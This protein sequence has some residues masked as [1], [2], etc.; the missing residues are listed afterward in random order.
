[1]GN[2][3]MKSTLKKTL[4]I[5]TAIA[6]AAAFFSGLILF[7]FFEKWKVIIAHT[8]G[9]DARMAGINIMVKTDQMDIL[10][11][12]KQIRI[13][14][15]CQIL[16]IV[17]CSVISIIMLSR[18]YYIRILQ[19]PIAILKKEAEYIG[20]N[21]L[22]FECKY[23]STDEMGEICRAFNDMRLRLIDNQKS[24][25]EQMEAQRQLN[26]AF[27]HDIRT[28]V[29]VIKGYAQM[30]LEFKASGMLSDEKLE[31]ILNTFLIQA[32][33]VE[34]F[35]STMKELH[36]IDERTVDKKKMTFNSIAAQLKSG[37]EGMSN[38]NISINVLFK[39]DERELFCDINFIHEV[40]DNLVSNAL[41]YAKKNIDISI[42]AEGSTLYVYVRDDGTGFMKDALY[43]AQRPYFT[44][45]KDHFGL[46]LA[47]CRTLCKKHGGD[48]QL[49]NSI[50]GGAIATA[51]FKCNVVK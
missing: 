18:Q 26:A 9:I 24:M 21:D 15:I 5:Y 34:T 17:L 45:E 28:P 6:L 42:E 44:T 3:K 27:A 49:I 2:L 46:G 39:E 10:Y 13:V 35:S 7:I 20:R 29:T 32:E 30:L 16:S 37:A 36:S 14:R 47:I 40:T 25:W 48:I 22:S 43:K 51:Y 31:E 1:M 12:I 41:R 8:N 4:A 19:E 23:L 38:E 50:K 33:R 11:S